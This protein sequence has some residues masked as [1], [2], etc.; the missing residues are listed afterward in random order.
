M[1]TSNRSIPRL[2]K[3]VENEEMSFAACSGCSGD[4]EDP[5]RTAWEQDS[6]DADTNFREEVGD[7]PG[8][9]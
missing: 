5:D 9:H 3:S 4:Y 7:D 8:V 2:W 1:I 6:E